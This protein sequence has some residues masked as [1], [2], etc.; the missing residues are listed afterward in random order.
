MR[1]L[2]WDEL[3]F[4][5]CLGVVPD[6]DEYSTYFSYKVLTGDMRLDLTVFPLESVVCLTLSQGT[7][8]RPLL[9][10]G[11]YVRGE[12]R[13]VNDMRGEYLEF[14]DSVVVPSNYTPRQDD[15]ASSREHTV[16]GITLQLAVKPSISVRIV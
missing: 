8:E 16:F 4:L 15:D 10:L 11:L 9:D 6:E 5:E 14:Q 1:D 2:Q 12:A 7:A 13:H 3:D